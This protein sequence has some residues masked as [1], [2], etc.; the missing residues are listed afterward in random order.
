ML[1]ALPSQTSSLGMYYPVA[2]V[3][4]SGPLLVA[5]DRSE[6][7]L[8][9][10]RA[11]KA[12]NSAVNR[13]VAVIA[14]IEPLPL[15]VP[16]PSS[17]LQPLVIS[18][19]LVAVV[20]DQVSRQVTEVGA[21]VAE[22][23]IE[24]EQG[25]PAR[26]IAFAA[27]K[28]FASIIILGL[29]RHSLVDR[30]IDG[31]TALELLRESDTPILLASENFV[32]VPKRVLIAVDFSPESIEAARV[33]LPLL[34]SDCVVH[35]AHV[36]PSVTIFDGSGLWEDEYERVAVKQLEGFREALAAPS[37]M[38]VEKTILVGRPAAA[39]SDYANKIDADLIVSGTHGVGRM[40][41]IFIGSVAG[42][43][44]RKSERSLLVVPKPTNQQ[45]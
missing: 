2:P 25:R 38:R 28:H 3:K 21:D 40:R 29:S 27:Q 15:I 36:R 17:L 16:E 14:V 23:P 8:S 7:S 39:L 9:A 5:T 26:E 6:V 18:P 24:V 37:T 42:G 33:S 1:S 44:L 32:S 34:A 10:L 31:D 4:V 19:E 12:L 30:I 43:L 45:K 13:G 22:W 20:R 11:A 41:R 35:L